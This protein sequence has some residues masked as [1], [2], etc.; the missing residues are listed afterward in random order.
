MRSELPDGTPQDV[1]A[2]Q[3]PILCV[4]GSRSGLN[5]LS[6]G[7]RR[8]GF[9]TLTAPDRGAAIALCAQKRPA[10]AIVNC[11]ISGGSGI[12]LAR[13]LQDGG[14]L[15]VILVA[16]NADYALLGQAADAGAMSVLLEPVELSH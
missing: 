5:H 16:T 2:A 6:A 7:L 8:A 14:S 12:E 3:A 4:D 13:R 9:A 11:V 1:V 15:P 10:L